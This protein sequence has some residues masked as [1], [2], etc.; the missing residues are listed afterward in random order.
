M[1]KVLIT[2]G[3]EGIGYALAECFAADGYHVILAARTKAKLEAAKEISRIGRSSSRQ[4]LVKLSVS[5]HFDH[6]R[7]GEMLPAVDA[8]EAATCKFCGRTEKLKPLPKYVGAFC[9]FC[10]ERL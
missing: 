3:S 4:S 8:Y 5:S 6:E 2:G 9:A 1:R 10:G 7:E